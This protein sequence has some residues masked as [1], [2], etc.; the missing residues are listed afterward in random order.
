VRLVELHVILENRFVIP[1]NPQGAVEVDVPFRPL[2]QALVFKS[3]DVGKV[4]Q[5]RESKHRQEFLRRDLGEGRAGFGRTQGPVDEIE[6]G[7]VNFGFNVRPAALTNSV[8]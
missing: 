1:G 4:A 7:H 8:G 3:L 6:A 5:C 2:Q